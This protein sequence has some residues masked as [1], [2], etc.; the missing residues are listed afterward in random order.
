MVQTKIYKDSIDYH[1]ILY[2]QV[3]QRMKPTDFGNPTTY[4]ILK[5]MTR[6]LKDELH[7]H[8]QVR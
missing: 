3:P 8:Q 6:F 4:S 2:S 7:F 5:Y 1:E